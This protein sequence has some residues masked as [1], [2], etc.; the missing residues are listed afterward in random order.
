MILK[1]FKGIKWKELK[2]WLVIYPEIGCKKNLENGWELNPCFQPK[3]KL[4][5]LHLFLEEHPGIE[6]GYVM[7]PVAF[8]RQK[9]DN[10]VFIPI[11]TRFK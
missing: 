4:K 10:I 2:W 8:E 1:L 9:V 7:S 3:G 6:T 11:Y 5:S